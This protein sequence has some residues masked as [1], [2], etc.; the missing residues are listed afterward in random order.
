MSEEKSNDSQ[1]HIIELSQV[2]NQLVKELSLIKPKKQSDEYSKLVVSQTV[3]ILALAYEKIR[4]AVEY[5]EDHLIRRAAI[6]RILRRRLSLNPEGKNEA[7]N[8]LRELLWARY[9]ANG[10]LGELD[11]R[12]VQKIIDR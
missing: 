8:V 7:E 1:D 3:S 4:N 6:E 11:N 5:R 10:S 2:T 12:E 9:F